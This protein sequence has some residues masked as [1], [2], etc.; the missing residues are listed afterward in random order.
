VVLAID[1]GSCSLSGSTVSFVGVG[2]CVIDANQPGNQDYLDAPQTQQSITIAPA[3]LTATANDQARQFGAANPAFTATI[4]GY[5]NGEMLQT[6]GVSGF[7]SC[8]TSATA[9]TPSGSYPITCTQGTLSASNYT[10][11]TFVPGTLTIAASKSV[12]GTQSG[13]ITVG[14]GQSLYVGPGATV[15]GPLTIKQGGSLEV[16][17]GKLTGPITADGAGAIRIC[18][19]TVT[20]P[21][22]I[23]GSSGLVVLGDNDGQVTCAGNSLAAKVQITGNTAGVE[24]DGNAYGAP[25]TITGNTG[26]LSAPDSGTVDAAGNSPAKGSNPPV[27]LQG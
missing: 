26:T 2:S 18:Q 10:F 7:A 1:S 16:A 11:A 24:F 13:P 9:S 21:I 20:A 12:S 22:T 4:S 25:V 19:A 27:N 5:V 8:S 3:S 23:T 15:T 6:S 14:S 17:G